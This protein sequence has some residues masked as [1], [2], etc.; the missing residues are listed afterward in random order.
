MELVEQIFLG[1]IESYSQ[2][3]LLY[4]I[5]N[6]E[7]LAKLAKANLNGTLFLAKVFAKMYKQQVSIL[8]YDNVMQ[9]LNKERPDLYVV[10]KLNQVNRNWMQKQVIDI[11]QMLF[12][13]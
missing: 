8:T 3:D 10:I 11:K 2:K 9:W 7:S 6:N 4:A 12:G 1:I 5:N 13:D